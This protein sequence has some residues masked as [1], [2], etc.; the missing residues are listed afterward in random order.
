[1][2]YVLSFLNL[3][4]LT[5]LW[6]GIRVHIHLEFL[7]RIFAIIILPVQVGQDCRPCSS[8][9]LCPTYDSRGALCFLICASVV[10]FVRPCV[11]SLQVK[12]F[13]QGSFW[14]SLSPINLKL[15]THVPHDI[16]FLILM[17]NYSFDPNFMVQ[18]T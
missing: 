6:S 12:V 4:L 17:S 10:P 18:W 3:D 5:N 15:G 16:I 1:M 11:R 2:L 13:G 8:L 7:I 9:F 14:R